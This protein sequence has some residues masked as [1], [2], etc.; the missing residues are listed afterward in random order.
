MKL[1][2]DGATIAIEGPPD[3]PGTLHLCLHS[4]VTDSRMWAATARACALPLA[5][6]DRRGFGRTELTGAGAWSAVQDTLAVLDALGAERAVLVGCS[7]GGRVAL[8]T[9]L[10]A[11]SRV[12]AL[13]L[14]APAVSG[15]PEPVLQGAL[16]ALERELDEAERAGDLAR[17]GELEAS[18]WLDGPSSPGRVGEP[19]R[20]LFLD[21]NGLALAGRA[22]AELPPPSAW[23][24]LEQLAMPVRLLVGALDAPFVQDRCDT[25]AQRIPG[26]SLTRWP[27]VAHLPPLEQPER[28]A[29]WLER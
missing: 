7:Q 16:A 2:L 4:G 22:P 29:R 24:R 15:A 17:L 25:L 20:S 8:D 5:A 12:E 23:E 28:F 10:H 19:L 9:A 6:F 11:P 1:E 18:L 3:R 13:V 14:V 27:D 21:M 26:A